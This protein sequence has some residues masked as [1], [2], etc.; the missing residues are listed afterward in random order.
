[1]INRR[2]FVKQAIVGLGVSALSTRSW[3]EASSDFDIVISGGQVFDGTGGPAWTTDIGIVGDT[4]AALEKIPS[5]R[6]KIHIDATGLQI[7]P[8]FIDIHTHSSVSVLKYPTADSRVRQGITTEITGNCGGSAA[9]VGKQD[10]GQ[11]ENSEDYPITWSD[12]AS[13]FKTVEEKRISLNQA[14]LLGQGTLR[15][16]VIG[17]GDRVVKPEELAQI[18]RSLEEGLDQGAVGLSTG[19][20][21]V[22]GVYTPMEELIQMARIVARRGGFYASHVRNEEAG[23]LS[24]I[25]EAIEI[26]RQTG[27]RVEVSHLKACGRANWNKQQAAIDLIESARKEGIEVLADAYPYEAWSTDLDVLLQ[28][29]V[30]DGGAEA[31]VGRLSDPALREQLRK[32]IDKQIMENDAGYDGIYVSSLDSEKNRLL[33]GKNLLQIAELWKIEPV[34]AYVRLLIEEK[35]VVSYIG[36]GINPENVETVLSHPLVMIGSD[37]YSLMAEKARP[38]SKPHPRSYGTYPRFLGHYVRERKLMDWPAAIRKATSMP[39][40]QVGLKDRGRIARGKRADIVVFDSNSIIDEATFENPER[41]SKGVIHV[42]VNGVPVVQNEKHTGKTPGRI[43]RM[44]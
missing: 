9:P 30:R 29:W 13:Y 21:Y 43:L 3:I 27:I 31:I 39:A 11:N 34:D 5:D 26:G 8:G 16:N 10:Q 20:E 24:A 42:F 14:M 2:A 4:I 15:S 44:S 17:S 6:G 12:V 19:L 22:P 23:L 33:I 38:D 41:Y 18:L 25:N 36:H 28:P 32:E 40:D 35:D 7:S 37:G 1:M